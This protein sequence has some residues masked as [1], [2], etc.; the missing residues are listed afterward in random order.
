MKKTFL[1]FA[2]LMAASTVSFAQVNKAFKISYAIVFANNSGGTEQEGPV[3]LYEAYVSN[4]KIK[5][6]S[7]AEG[8]ESIFL[9]KRMKINQRS[10]IPPYRNTPYTKRTQPPSP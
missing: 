1:S 4:D 6:I 5:V 3:S 9:R 8:Q 7:S 2:V 10:F